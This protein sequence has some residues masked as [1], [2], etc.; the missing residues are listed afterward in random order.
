MQK[1]DQEFLKVVN[2]MVESY[3][4][5]EPWSALTFD[6]LRVQG[7]SPTM[8]K[9]FIMMVSDDDYRTLSLMLS[10]MHFR[11]GIKER[12]YHAILDELERIKKEM[13]T[14]PDDS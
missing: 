12:V 1:N 11:P 2:G 3:A 13:E 10:V 9:T 8:E 6:L 14:S 5:G 4:N 7:D